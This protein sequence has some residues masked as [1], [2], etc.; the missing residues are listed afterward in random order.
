VT[1]T[2]TNLSL[3]SAGAYA[4]I[5]AIR[6]R[7]ARYHGA[8]TTAAVIHRKFSQI[9]LPDHTGLRSWNRFERDWPFGARG[10]QQEHSKFQAQS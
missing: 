5:R 2:A 3:F 1:G 6:H 7:I 4:L 10:L 8:V 9:Q